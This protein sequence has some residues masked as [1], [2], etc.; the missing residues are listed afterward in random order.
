MYSQKEVAQNY[1]T[2]AQDKTS[3]KWYKTLILA[4]FAGAFIALAG[5][6]ATVAGTA[7]EGIRSTLIKAAV[8]PVGLILVILTGSELFTGNCLLLAPVLSKNVK[9]TSAL[10]NWGIVYGGNIIGSV[11]IALIVVYCGAMNDAT[12]NATVA[13]AAAK[14]ETSFWQ[15]FLRAIPC[16]ILVCLA[17]W[18]SMTSKNVVGKILAVYMPIFAFVICGFEHSVANM[19]YVTSGLLA[20]AKT[21][22]SAV[23]L[24]VGKS[25]LFSILP[26]TLGNI[27]GG[28]AFVALPLWIV[29]FKQANNTERNKV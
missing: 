18:T 27:V 23:N 5:F 2:I 20:S 12:A 1:I 19:Y 8:F 26:T 28:M 9:I 17:V 14:C 24:T 16:N 25:L 11:I 22:I 6:T 29:H 10:K 21:G 7:Y 13:C 4:I 15:S 3:A